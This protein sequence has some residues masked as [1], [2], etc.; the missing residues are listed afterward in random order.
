MTIM[1]AP[2]KNTWYHA[3]AQPHCGLPDG[4]FPH[5]PMVTPTGRPGE[6]RDLRLASHSLVH[7]G[8]RAKVPAGHVSGMLASTARLLLICAKH[9]FAII[10]TPL[11]IF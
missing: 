7:T 2:M 1:T 8:P 5:I 11:P 4:I 10:R 3:M 6:L 9:A